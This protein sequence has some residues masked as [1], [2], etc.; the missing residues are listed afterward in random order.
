MKISRSSAAAAVS[1]LLHAGLLAAAAAGLSGRPDKPAE[2]L[3]ITIHLVAEQKI[4]TP[5]APHPVVPVKPPPEKKR[6]ER[7]PRPVPKPVQPAVEPHKQTTAEVTTPIV[8]P[9]PPETV[10]A[11]PPV[12]QAAPPPSEPVR[13]SVSIPAS[14]AASNRKPR[15]PSLSRQ[16][17]EQGTVMLRVFVKAD[18]TA[19]QIEIKSSSG[20]P[21]LD[22]SAKTA[23][24]SWRFNPATSDGK[25]VA[26][27]FLIPIPFKLQN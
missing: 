1:L 11:A 25:P 16:Y 18:G 21:L 2:P 4:D 3:P 27:W 15:Y 8:P 7:K 13:T 19:G 17:E 14:Y 6:A 26:D 23:V 9:A 12:P 10:S 24:Q 22:Q 20:Y 5:P